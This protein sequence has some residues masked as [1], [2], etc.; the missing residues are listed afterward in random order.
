MLVQTSK[1]RPNRDDVDLS[2]RLKHGIHT[3]F[4]FVDP[5]APFS[6][7]TSQLLDVLRERY[8]GGLTTSVAPPKSTPIPDF[9]ESVH[10]SYAVLK[11]PHDPSQGWRNLGVSATD[12][13][14]E[15]GLKNNCAVA[16][17]FQ[18]PD[19]AAG[20]ARF[21]VEWPRLGDDYSDDA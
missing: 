10:V 14:A 4:L 16:F 19:D 3:V 7:I 8:P 15:K 12:T 6:T 18:D 11:Y 13:P 1:S 21:E 9:S 5:L 17:A 20:D 2:I